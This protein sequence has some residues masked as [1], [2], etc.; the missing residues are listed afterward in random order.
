MGFIFGVIVGFAAFPF[1]TL[2]GKTLY[3]A[4]K[5]TSEKW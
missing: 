2:C 5:N 1:L 4:L 3:K